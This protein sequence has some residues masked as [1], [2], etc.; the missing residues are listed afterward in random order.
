MKRWLVALLVVAVVSPAWARIT[1]EKASGPAAAPTLE[2]GTF[3]NQAGHVVRK[4]APVVAGSAP[5]GATAH[6][7]DN[8]YSFDQGRRGACRRHGGVAD[9][10]GD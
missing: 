1:V 9:W 8:T 10:L 7:G 2:P 5:A 4:A 6:C 3:I